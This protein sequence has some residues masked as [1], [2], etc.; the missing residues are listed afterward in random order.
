MD[1]ELCSVASDEECEVFWDLASDEECDISGD[2]EGCLFCEDDGT[3]IVSCKL[4][5]EPELRS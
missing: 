5:N 2:A 3:L 4:I 1:M